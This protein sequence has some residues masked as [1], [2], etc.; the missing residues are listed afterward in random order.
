M[1]L[2][3]FYDKKLAQA[4]YM[5]GD[6]QTGEALVI[7]PARDIRPYLEAAHQEKV[8]IAQVAETHIH[9]DFAS[10]GRELAHQTGARLYLSAMGGADWQYAIPDKNVTLLHD[11]DAF[12]VGAVR[13]EALHTPGHTPEH[14]VFQITDS[15]AASRPIGLFTGDFLFVGD[16]GRPDL[17]EAAAGMTG[18]R[19]N[20]ARQQFHNV[21]RFKHLPDY[22]QIWPGHG[23]GS[24]CG[25]ALGAL[26]STTLGYEKLVNPAFQIADESEFV[27][28]LL[29]GQ[30]EAPRY[31]A[32]MKQVNKCGPALLETLVAPVH[33]TDQT[34]LRQ[35]VAET[36]VIDT[37]PA[38]DF[39][40]AHIPGTLHIPGTSDR[41]STYAG[42][43]VDY[44]Q[45]TYLIIA[46]AERDRLLGELRAI[47]VDNIPGY[48]TPEIVTGD[49]E[50][51]HQISPPDAVEKL[52]H[53]NAV[54]LDVRGKNEREDQRIPGTVH[55]PMGAVS[56]H[57]DDL[58]RDELLIV[59]C[60]GGVRS[61]VVTSLLQKHGF[62]NV[63]NL[64]G[65]ID[66]W[67]KAG[68]PVKAD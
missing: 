39:V 26:P 59:Q 12:Q 10:G 11:G 1:F 68:L 22:L 41:F 20:S 64:I 34:L 35:L 65:G 53:G 48:F 56:W 55:I 3:Y 25:K 9:A 45:P 47:G 46:E 15:A 61:L 52:Q 31:F 67:K 66:G 21:Q 6:E 58:P 23:A 43:Y 40:R 38:P 28:W 37:R 27:R 42:W 19:E 13:V 60:G 54:L 2:K 5:I 30:P 16:V 51:S 63:A 33:L 4:S 14:L 50:Q 17:L 44:D 62:R 49:T 36:L 7:D 57:L 18:T 32:R 24:A 8:R 29:D